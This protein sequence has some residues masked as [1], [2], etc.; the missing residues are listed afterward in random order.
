M[1]LAACSFEHGVAGRLD[2]A[3]TA[4]DVAIDAAID[5][6]PVLVF[7]LHVEAWMDGRS[8]LLIAGNKLHWHHYQFAAPGREA[9]ENYPTKLDGVDWY[10]TWPDVPDAENRECNC[11]SSTYTLPASSLPSVPAMTTLTITQ[12]RKM[13]SVVQ[14]PAAAN[15]YTLIVALTDVGAGGSSWDILDIDVFTH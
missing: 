2:A 14:E 4:P 10:P 9:F 5:A 6:P 12:V 8:N 1:C 3:D 15:G 13:P 11:D 7:H